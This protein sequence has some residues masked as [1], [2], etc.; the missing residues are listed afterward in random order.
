MQQSVGN[1][2]NRPGAFI[3]HTVDKKQQEVLEAHDAEG[4][5]LTDA[6]RHVSWT[7]GQIAT[8][9]DPHSIQEC[10]VSPQT[11]R[12]KTRASQ[13]ASPPHSA[14]APRTGSPPSTY[15]SVGGHMGH[16]PMVS[17]KTLP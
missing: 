11:I 12:Q 10:T 7:L 13:T 9:K 1:G 5:P 2:K 16:S 4:T 8:S 15:T 3:P 17:A 6:R 14:G